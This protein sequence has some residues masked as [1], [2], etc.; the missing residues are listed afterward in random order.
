MGNPIHPPEYEAFLAGIEH[1]RE[2]R[3][4]GGT[5]GPG[6]LYP[7]FVSYR[8][9]RHTI[10]HKEGI[11]LLGT[12]LS[13]QLGALKATPEGRKRFMEFL[14]GLKDDSAI[15]SEYTIVINPGTIV[16]SLAA[17]K[18]LT[19]VASDLIPPP[20]DP[21]DVGALTDLAMNWMT[22]K[23]IHRDDIA[24]I[25]CRGGMLKPCTGGTFLVGAETVKDLQGALV[26]HPSNLGIPIG[27]RLVE[28]L[29]RDDIP[30]TTTDP[31]STDEFT[32]LSRMTGLLDFR[33]HSWLPHYCNHRSVARATCG[34]LGIPYEN[35]VIVTAHVGDGISAVRHNNG[36]IE[37]IRNAY[38]E[39][40]G[41]NRSGFIPIEE[42]MF[43]MEKGVLTGKDLRKW[44]FSEGGLINLSGTNDFRILMEFR[45]KG[46]MDRQRDKTELLLEFYAQQV[47]S[48]VSGL[49]AADAKPSLIVL[50]GGVMNSEEMAGR[51]TIKLDGTVPVAIVP[52]NA[53]K[54]SLAAG[55]IRT[56]LDPSSAMNYMKEKLLFSQR[57]TADE[58]VLTLKL[59]DKPVYRIK[60][61]STARSVDDVIALAREATQHHGTPVIGVMG[62]A[63]EEVISAANLVNSSG[64]F[65]MARFLLAGPFQEISK[66]AWEHDL[67][68]DDD[69]Y[70][71]IDTEDPINTCMELYKSGQANMLMKGSITTEALMHAFIRTTKSMLAEGEK[72]FL[73]HV[74]VLDVPNRSKLL[75]LSDAGINPA[76]DKTAKIRIIRNA[77]TVAA[78]LNIRNPKVAVISAVEKVNPSVA[79]SVEAAAIAE[80]LKAES[81]FICEGPLSL[82]VATSPKSAAEK[83][84][85]GRIK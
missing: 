3:A 19:L 27:L 82:D 72:V 38:S 30:V 25:A 18:G 51:I 47:A 16:L 70:R 62:A 29:G 46:A 75:L 37:D 61:E 28:A 23:K 15:A 66:L 58:K 76:P 4:R 22:E 83:G 7:L 77:L 81:G 49:C 54:E 5:V 36:R 69:N 6:D 74:A 12:V 2:N 8:R 43:G 32:R 60:P 63:N 44:L 34:F 11:R 41:T 65:H 56:R 9:L 20:A 52:G 50:T 33:R 68:I 1:L 42:I 48:G 31:L 59:F 14:T 84:Y 21:R 85:G 24:G 67:N 71:I 10:I 64:C 13:E 79:S 35:T 45:T 78:A 53:I 40:P 17:Y 57:R 55:N 39:L 80:E 73:S 26:D